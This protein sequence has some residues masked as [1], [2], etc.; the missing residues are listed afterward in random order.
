M[1]IPAEFSHEPLDDTIYGMFLFLK[2]RTFLFCGQKF[3]TQRPH[4]WH[5]HTDS[6]TRLPIA[7]GQLV[8]RP[9]KPVYLSQ[10]LKTA[11]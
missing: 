7:I 3:P 10:H 2:L 6:R 5:G 11:V 1:P 4:V 9:G 8:S